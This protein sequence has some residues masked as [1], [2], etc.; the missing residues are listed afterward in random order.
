MIAKYKNDFY[1]YLKNNWVS[2]IIT[3]QKDKATDEFTYED[4][5]YWRHVDANELIDIF[6]ISY[7][8]EYL[9]NDSSLPTLW[10]VVDSANNPIKNDKI[11]ISFSNGIIPG[12]H[13]KERDVCIKELGKNDIKKAKIIKTY[14]QKDSVVLENPQVEE[15]YVSA[16]ELFAMLNMFSRRAL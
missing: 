13:I 16:N 10:E 7:W 15:L 14:Y 1:F 4:K 9:T 2:N 5:C 11:C 12:W 8:V 3:E 6:D